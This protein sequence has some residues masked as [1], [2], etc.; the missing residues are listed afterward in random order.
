MA[1][2]DEKYNFKKIKTNRASGVL[3]HISSLPGPYGIGTLGKKARE[4]VDFLVKA[5]QT[6]WQLLPVG[7]TGYGDSPYQSFSTFAGNPYFIDLDM[8]I[9]Q[10]LLTQE[11]VDANS[12]VE[13]SERVD[14]GRLY[15]DRYTLLEI[16][17]SR[18]DVS[19]KKFQSFAK[20]K[21]AWL[22]DYALYMAIK[23][24][25]EGMAWTQWPEEYKLRDKKAL[26]AF[27]KDNIERVN[28]QRFMQFIFFEQWEALKDYAHAEGIKFI[29][30]LPIYVAED[31]SD[32]WANPDLFKLNDDLSLK[33]VGGCPP[34][35]FSE[36]GQLWGNPVYDWPKHEK[37]NYKWWVERLRS[38]FEIFDM[39]RLDHFRG[40]ES[41][42]S[43]PAGEKTARN[44]EWIEGPAMKLFNQVKKSLGDIDIIAEDLGYMTKEVYEFRKESGFPSMK[45]L[46]FGFDP[47]ANS[48]YLPHNYDE[49]SVVYT[50]THDSDTILGWL[51][52]ARPEEIETARMY[53]NLTQEETYNWGLIRGAMTSVAK[54]AVFQMQD[55][56]FL[57]NKARMNNPGTLGG[58]WQWRM[59]DGAIT[60][61][62]TGILHEYT[63]LSGRL[64]P[65]SIKEKE[66]SAKKEDE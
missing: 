26:K 11:E 58:N 38:N 19:N 46:Q 4:F 45:V 37:T 22:D 7:P 29:G 59:K 17:F 3:M 25:L 15:Q 66:E 62:M 36:D 34:D 35:G 49:N 50:G 20:D 44:G 2:L 24:K 16:A 14:Y 33:F 47:Q 12:Q 28:Y 30:D 32:V 23:E 52:I 39:I 56:L 42:W 65:K 40:F 5:G 10:G 6:Y 27:E 18:F 57:D 63:R 53:F 61:F 21:K 9:E 1:V 48:D 41:Y 64:N 51:A 54:L 60:D 43:I 31:S 8:L 13:D 55:L